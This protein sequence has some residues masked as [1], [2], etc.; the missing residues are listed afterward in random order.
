[1][2]AAALLATTLLLALP[3]SAAQEA[4]DGNIVVG[5]V[6]YSPGDEVLELRDQYST[7]IVKVDGSLTRTIS[8]GSIN[9][10]DGSGN[11]QPI[12]TTITPSNKANWDWEVETG[13]WKLFVNNDTTIGAKKGNNWIGTRFHGIAYLD[14]VSKDYTI[15][16]TTNSVVPVVTGNTI[17]WYNILYGV[18]YVLYYNNDTLKEDIIIHQEARNLLASAGNRPSDYG[19]NASNTYL[20]PIFECDWSESL[21]MKVN[22]INESP[23]ELETDD[24]IYFEANTPDPY[25]Q[26]VL[27]SFLPVYSAVSENPINPEAPEVD[28]EFAEYVMKKR[29]VAKNDKHWLLVGLP[30]LTLNSMP[31]GSIIFDPTA[32][33]RPNAAGDITTIG[34]Q[35]PAAGEHWEKVDEVVADN[36]TTSLTST[37]IN[38]ED[39]YNLPDH[40][41]EAG[42]INFIEVFACAYVFNESDHAH[43]TIKSGGTI[44]EGA[45]LVDG[46]GT[47]NTFSTQWADNPADSEDWEWA[48][49]D[50][51][52]IGLRQFTHNL[53]IYFTQIY[54]EV[55]YTPPPEA[56]TNFAA[57][58][59]LDDT[60]TCTWTK[61]DG[62]TKYQLYRD[63]APIGAE[64]G[65]VATIDDDTAA[66]PTITAGTAV[67]SDGTETAHI[68]LSITG[69]SANDGTIYTYKVKAGSAAGWSGDSNTDNGNRAPGALT[70]QWERSAADSDE[71]YSNLVGATTEAHNDTTAPAG[72]VTPGV[73]SAT[74]GDFST[75]IVLSIAGESVAVGAGRYYKCVLNATGATEQTTGVNRG[76]RTTGEIT[77]AW[78]RSAADSD[79]GYGALGGAT[80]DPYDD[81]LG[82]GIAYWYYCEVSATG[83]ITQDTTHNRGFT[84]ELP[85]VTTQASTGFSKLWAIVN[86]TM[87]TEG[88]FAVT[89]VGFDYGLDTGYGDSSTDTGTWSDGATFLK[90][91]ES[92][93]PASVYH[94]RA[95]AYNGAWGY[96]VD[97][98]FSTQGSP[99]LY[100]YLNT[101]GDADGDD[102]YGNDWADQQFTTGAVSHTI[103][104]VRVNLKRV[105]SPGDVILSLY[106]ADAAHK[107]TGNAIVSDTLDGDVFAE[108][109]TWYEFTLTETRLEADQEFAIVIRATTGNATDYVEWRWDAGGGLADAVA[110]LSEDG[111]ISWTVDVGGADYLFEV[112]G[113]P[114]AIVVGAQVFSGYVDTGD[115]LITLTYEN[116][117]IPYYPDETTA[118]YFYLQFLDGAVIRAQ[119]SCKA[120]DY[121]PGS[122]YLSKS[123]T[124]TLE[125]GADDYTV[126]IYGDFGDNPYSDYLLTS[127]DW[128]GTDLTLL[129]AWVL[130]QAKAIENKSDLTLRIIDSDKGE[131]L[132]TAGKAMFALGIP[133]IKEIR[134]GLVDWAIRTSEYEENTYT[135]AL[136]TATDWET[137]IGADM[138]AKLE[139]GGA[140]LGVSGQDFG[141]ALL[142][143]GILVVM[144]FLASKGMI[145]IGMLVSYLILLFGAWVGLIGYVVLGVVTV[146]L[147]GGYFVYKAFLQ[148]G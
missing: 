128:R 84:I 54:V 137:N 23:D 135:D 107:P 94:Y 127:T 100:E 35:F 102:I 116:Y 46:V 77:Y 88:S 97:M 92:L 145:G 115:W 61:S 114:V 82:Q 1:M 31:E 2:T 7:T 122:I 20:V 76:Y 138:V 17:T 86:G 32:T 12:N 123:L 58:D 24:A 118:Q 91:L 15:L 125:W 34:T 51:L 119:G 147:G 108:V 85:V 36:A 110:G 22:G 59:N 93:S 131:I 141:A 40:T 109:S 80:T 10:E 8:L 68:T 65:D 95:K 120:W 124:D 53:D 134:P 117:Y 74:D 19:Y 56:P 105:G 99:V 90:K 64:L 146:V 16:Q 78:Q 96:G 129:D 6:N 132:N 66:A 126:R 49:I 112:W 42:T 13:H 144:A 18:D 48:D 121:K 3:V 11:F 44:Y 50:A 14:I 37:A 41:S 81:T 103:T 60:V 148:R 98:V 5:G 111:G 25:W 9:Y 72:V 55:D 106:Y 67:A 133:N 101:G 27:V 83:T 130:A 33:F 45:A 79:A 142:T 52:Q 28:W 139:T 104:S 87:V 38:Q 136:Q 57:T 26:T 43:L 69:E 47:F 71:E 4:L 89:Q 29:L 21:P 62:A 143:I 73:A 63:A 113:N 70:Y 140:I 75:K 30:V 39:L